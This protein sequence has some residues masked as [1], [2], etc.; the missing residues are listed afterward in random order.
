MAV[1]SSGQLREYA[2]IGVEL[3]VAQTNVSL[4]GMSQTAGFSTPD[5]M[6]EFY[7][8]SA[9]NPYFNTVLYTGDGASSRSITGV[10][11]QP[12]LVW[13]KQRGPSNSDNVL[14]DSVRGVNKKLASN[15]TAAEVSPS[16]YGAVSSF[17]SDGFTVAK[18]L[19]NTFAGGFEVNTNYSGATYVAWCWKAGGAAV[20]NTDGTIT[21]QVSANTQTG[22]SIVTYTGNGANGTVGHGLGTT[23]NV[24]LTKSRNNTS[25][26]SF[27]GNI[28]GLNY[29]T[30][31]LTLNSTA[32]L[33]IDQNEVLAANSSTFTAGQSSAVGRS[34]YTYV[35]YCF[36]EVAGLSK[37]GSFVGNGTTVSITTGFEP[38]FVLWKNTSQG[39]ASYDY[40]FIVD[41]KRS[42]SN[43]VKNIL[44]PNSYIVDG[45]TSYTI[46]NFNSNGFDIVGDQ[47]SNRVFNNSGDT[48]L[49]MAFA[50]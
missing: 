27:N 20:T 8:Y 3:G 41:N 50:K 38:A 21:S 10:G 47:V 26:W 15:T 44:Y 37:F 49:Y 33:S 6:S 7:G 16:I 14:N 48:Y 30:S 24:V 28:G 42:P 11:F 2:D 4:R 46:A 40:W 35:A 23:P 34:G 22:F 32:A 5:A 25:N 43:P 13:I 19:D 9:S 31:K 39:S 17:D 18:G 36:A 29:G 12:D 45:T 1:P